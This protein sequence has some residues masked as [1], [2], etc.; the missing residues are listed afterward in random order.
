MT[1]S[2]P[3]DRTPPTAGDVR[4]IAIGGG[5]GAG[6]STLS[7]NVQAIVS[8]RS[9]CVIV[10]L[11]AYFCDWSHPPLAQRALVNFDEP[12]AIE[13][14]RLV[15]DLQT[16]REGRP[17]ERPWY[18]M[19][20]HRRGDGTVLVEPASIIIVD[21]HLALALDACLPLY[22]P[23]IFVNT[24]VDERLRRRRAA[25]PTT[26]ARCRGPWPY[27]AERAGSMV[28]VRTTDVRKAHRT[29]GRPSES[30]GGRSERR[31]LAG[32]KGHRSHRHLKLHYCSS[33]RVW[34]GD[35]LH[36]GVPGDVATVVAPDLDQC[37]DDK[38]SSR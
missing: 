21:G 10:P 38:L 30:R 20:Q 25:S 27:R 3:D 4:V 35:E 24:A 29:L 32:C 15:T 11:E 13:V 5:S 1:V 36:V 12:A 17:V 33:S 2:L 9:S 19:T 26:S 18:D 34:G 37:V 7:T 28:P 8:A 22:D 23:K 16:L 6:K 31:Q 14:S